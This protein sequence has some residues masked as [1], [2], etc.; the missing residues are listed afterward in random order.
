MFKNKML[1]LVCS[2]GLLL[3]SAHGRKQWARERAPISIK[4][5]DKGTTFY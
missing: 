5:L 3:M 2:E 4:V 1:A